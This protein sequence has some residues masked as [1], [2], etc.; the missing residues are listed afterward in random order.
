[1][2][3]SMGLALQVRGI[4]SLVLDCLKCNCVDLCYLEAPVERTLALPVSLVI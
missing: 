4:Y 3:E 2:H 1:M